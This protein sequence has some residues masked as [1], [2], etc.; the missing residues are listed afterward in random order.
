MNKKYLNSILIVLL[1]II[2]CSV[3]YKYFGGKKS[4]SENIDAITLVSNYKQDYSIIKDT[5]QLKLSVRD[6][7]GVSRRIAK[8]RDPKKN[9]KAKPKKNLKSIKRSLLW[10][11]ITYHGFVKGENKST[12]L[13]LLKI[14]S[15]LYRK[16]EKEIV[17]NITLVKAYNDSLIVSLNNTNKTIKK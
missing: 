14:N 1:I 6:P 8:K 17:N 7:F 2:W 12:R 3:F 13:I 10:P 15:K 11:S 5:F 9:S 4:S 16:R